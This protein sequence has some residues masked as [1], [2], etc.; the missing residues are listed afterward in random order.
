MHFCIWRCSECAE[1][2]ETPGKIKRQLTFQWEGATTGPPMLSPRVQDE[3]NYL[4]EINNKKGI[5]IF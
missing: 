5:N 2:L 4:S 1:I 3:L